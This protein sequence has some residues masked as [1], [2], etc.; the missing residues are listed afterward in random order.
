MPY[1]KV[2][3][4]GTLAGGEIW[5]CGMAFQGD[6]QAVPVISEFEELQEWATGIVAI[7]SGQVVTDDLHALMSDVCAVTQ[8]RTEA[9]SDT[10][11]VL[12]AATAAP[13]AP[14]PGIGSA[15]MPFQ[16]SLVFSL[17]TGRPGRSYAGRVYW[18][19]I[20][21]GI[22]GETARVTATNAGNYLDAF[23]A[24]L[25][26]ITAAAPTGATIYPAVASTR[27][28]ITT[29]VTTVRVGNVLDTQRRR[30]DSLAEVYVSQSV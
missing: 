28:G 10:G 26:G 11:D 7:N 19:A 18:P 13:S 5:S 20:G 23:V 9:V 27:L 21:A 1:N 16:T 4:S 17:D 14:M 3:I 2:I 15:K 6:G 25:N 30:R 29:R 12:M 24:L 22:D 8:V